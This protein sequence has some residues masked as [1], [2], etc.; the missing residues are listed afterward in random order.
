MIENLQEFCR[1]FYTSTF[2][3]V[4]V[5]RTPGTVLYSYPEYQNSILNITSTLP[6]MLTFHKNPDYYLMESFCYFGQ[7]SIEGSDEFL[8]IGPVFSVPVTESS[9]RMFMKECGISME[10][11]DG[12][13]SFLNNTPRISFNQFTQ[14]LAFL[15]LSLN[16]QT[17]DLA[18]HFH[19]DDTPSLEEISTI[20]SSQIHDAKEEQLFHNTYSFEQQYLECVKNGETIRLKKLMDSVEHRL[21]MGKIGDTLL[22]NVKNLMIACTTLTTRAAIAG[23]MDIEQAYQLSDVYINEGEKMQSVKA[24]A[25]LQRTMIFDFTERVAKNKL[26]HGMSKEISDC[27]QFISQHTNE[28]IRVDDVAAFAGKSKTYISQKFKKELGF[29]I[30]SFIMR[31]KLEEAK[32]LLTYSDQSLSE[33]SSYLCFSSQAYFQNVFKKKYGLTPMQYR[34]QTIK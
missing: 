25:T 22:R 6:Y 31:C 12:I 14:T 34:N 13:T 24:L 29:D 2:I 18:R 9:I 21:I 4:N 23:G 32:S 7:I 28:L 20:H 5:C 30:S 17:V 3:P 11:K 10:F 16:N 8:I 19:L 1:L 33:I 27:I 15:H 26:P